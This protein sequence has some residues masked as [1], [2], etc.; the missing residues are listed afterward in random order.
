M[1]TVGI[2]RLRG[3]LRSP[4]HKAFAAKSHE[5]SAVPDLFYKIP[6]QLSY[7]GNQ[8]Y[9]DCHDDKT[10][11]LTSKGWKSWSDYDGETPLATMNQ[12]SRMLE[13]QAPTAITRRD[14]DGPMA[15]ATHKGMDF[16]VTPN[17]RML[18]APY[19]I[20][21]GHRNYQKGTAGYGTFRFGTIDQLPGRVLIPGTTLGFIGTDLKKLGIGQRT[22]DGDDLIRLIAVIAADGWVT[23]G[24]QR[25]HIGFC[26]FR[27]DRREMVASLAHRLGIEETSRRGVWGFSDAALAEWLR[28]NLYT[29]QEL[30]ALNKRIPDLIKVAS[31][32]QIGQFL[33]YFGDQTIQKTDSESRQFFSSSKPLIDD[34]QELLLR[35][36]KRGTIYTH[37][38]RSGGTI[39][40]KVITAN[41]PAYTLHE[42]QNTDLSIARRKDNPGIEFDHYKGEVFCATV[43]NS[44]LITRR[45]GRILISGN[46]VSAEEAAAKAIYS[47]MAGFPEIFITEQVLINWAHQHGF[48]NGANL[49]DVMDAM[50]RTGIVAS[51][52]KTYTD[53]PYQSVDWTNDAILSS[54]IFAGP[55]KIGVAADQLQNTVGQSNGWIGVGFKTDNNID[56]CVNLCG[57]GTMEALCQVM[58]V[59]LPAG[60][61]PT[62][63]GYLLFTWDT[64][65]II[66]RASM[67]AITAEAWLRTPTTPQAPMPVPTPTP[68]PVPPTP[69]P[70]PT[71]TPVP[72]TPTPTPPP[73]PT[74]TP[75]PP[76][77]AGPLSGTWDPTTGKATI[78][79]FTV[80]PSGRFATH[81]ADSPAALGAINWA[82]IIKIIQDILADLT[83]PSPSPT[84]TPVSAASQ[85]DVIN[86]HMAPHAASLGT[87]PWAQIIQIVLAILA[88]LTP[89]KS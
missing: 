56:H 64:I 22:W 44:T 70:T 2:T 21:G 75:V 26:C 53:G 28:V 48:L 55:V 12:Q 54:A 18:Y 15:F 40:G 62:T 33:E 79:G 52:G 3:A 41:G 81:D 5:P 89:P 88:Q 38:P 71:P 30:G 29:S 43:P 37:A 86:R 83:P 66:D 60:I 78:T 4:A 49:T 16:A 73:L 31:Q 72:P 23:N 63:R 59:T 76:A 35:F 57:F 34:L 32:E 8:T 87:L 50:S 10:E 58:N 9:G 7:W 36:G 82:L 25:N 84:P 65:G 68:T 24:V 67:I 74:P 46:C 13:F 47:V 80:T 19:V 17:H 77:P 51:D 42:Y 27:E 1:S 11:V 69:T 14:H 20:P 85:L 39:N 61:S 45:E 6:S